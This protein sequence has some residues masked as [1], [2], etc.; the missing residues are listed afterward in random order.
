MFGGAFEIFPL[1]YGR[2]TTLDRPER[3]PANAIPPID[4]LES[5]FPH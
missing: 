1:F 2:I 3:P 4:K 5:E